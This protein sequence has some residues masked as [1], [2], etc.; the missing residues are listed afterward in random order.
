MTSFVQNQFTMG[1]GAQTLFFLAILPRSEF[2]LSQTLSLG[3]TIVAIF[4]FIFSMLSEDLEMEPEWEPSVEHEGKTIVPSK[5][6]LDLERTIKLSALGTS[7]IAIG[8]LLGGIA[9]FP[10]CRQEQG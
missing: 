9:S 7:M 6:N 3:S 8:L 1:I 5:W 2:R 4:A 10:E